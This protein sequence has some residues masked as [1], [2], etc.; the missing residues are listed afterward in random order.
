MLMSRGI[1]FG[2][3]GG[4]GRL[5]VIPGVRRD[6]PASLTF[7][8]DGHLK[9]G[10]HS[11]VHQARNHALRGSDTVGEVRL[12]YSVCDKVIAKLAHGDGLC[13]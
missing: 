13:A 7:D 4:F 3:G 10:L 8:S 9:T 5:T 6:Q 11:A 1:L 2:G 12:P